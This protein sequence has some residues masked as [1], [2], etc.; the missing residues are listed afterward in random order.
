MQL[1]L[2]PFRPKGSS[3]ALTVQAWATNMITASNSKMDSQGLFATLYA[4]RASPPERNPR[5]IS[6]N[7]GMETFTFGIY[8]KLHR[9]HSALGRA[10]FFLGRSERDQITAQCLR[11][12]PPAISLVNPSVL[13]LSGDAIPPSP[14]KLRDVCR[15][16][17]PRE[18]NWRFTP[19][20]CS[21]PSIYPSVSSLFFSLTPL[22]SSLL[23]SS[24][25]DLLRPYISSY[26]FFSF[27]IQPSHHSTSSIAS[28]IKV[29]M[30]LHIFNIAI[31]TALTL[32]VAVPR[33]ILLVSCP[34]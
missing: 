11:S 27:P 33:I 26:S 29:I 8:G 9:S 14:L 5:Y 13:A 4:P 31:C 24:L 6:H 21:H 25:F 30:K 12:T 17:T 22:S 20:A 15:L 32:A 19:P 34:N 28:H 18:G 7:T 23:Y 1:C 3:S 16:P 10:V 2:V